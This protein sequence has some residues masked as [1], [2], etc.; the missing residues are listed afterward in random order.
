MNVN[1]L[2]MGSSEFSAP[3]LIALFKSYGLKSVVTQPDKPTGRGKRLDSPVVKSIALGLGIPVFQPKKLIR[4]DL[5]GILKEFQIELIVVAAYG[6]ILPGWLLDCPKFGAIN[7][8]GSL[9]PKYRGAS[10]I[11]TAILNGDPCTGVTIMKVDEGLDTGDILSQKSMKINPQETAGSLS[12]RMA[13]LGAQLLVDTIKDYV[14]GDVIPKKQN[15]EEATKTKL[16]TKEDGELDLHQPA[17]YLE[18]KIRAFNPW[19]V[20]FVKFDKN[21]LRIYEAEIAVEKLDPFQRGES[22]K[23]PIIGTATNALILKTVQPAGRKIMDGRSF[24]NGTNHWL[25]SD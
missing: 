21:Y 16:I 15:S 18:R 10:P 8:H 4:E 3:V 12:E 1:I 7:V 2:F 20:C 17:D 5:I 14:S 19:P 13:K 6:K 25:V 23:Y 11:Q 9:L 24:L 22:K